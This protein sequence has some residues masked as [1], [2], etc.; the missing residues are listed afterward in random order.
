MK[1]LKSL[2][3]KQKPFDKDTGPDGLQHDLSDIINKEQSNLSK[4]GPIYEANKILTLNPEKNKVRA[5]SHR[6]NSVKNTN[7]KFLNIILACEIQQYTNNKHVMINWGYSSKVDLKLE[8][9]FM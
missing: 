3:Q 8:N 2:Y 5:E 9:S 6:P 1:E 7:V 4:T